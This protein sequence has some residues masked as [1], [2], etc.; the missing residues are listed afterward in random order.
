M[1]RFLGILGRGGNVIAIGFGHFLHLFQGPD[2]FRQFFP[3]PDDV[4]GHDAAAAVVQI[5]AFLVDQ[6]VDAVESHSPVVPHDAAPAVGVGQTGYNVAVTGPAHFSGVGI[7]HGL[8][9]GLVVFGEDLVELGVHFVPVGFRRFFRHFDAAVGHEGPFQRLVGLEAHHL[10]QILHGFIDVAGAV[11]RQAGNHFRFAVQ[12]AAFGPFFLLE[13]L[14][15]SPQFVGGFRRPCQEAFV[16]VIR[17]IVVLDEIPDIHI[18]RPFH[19][20]K[21]SPCNILIDAVHYRSSF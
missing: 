7:E 15:L 10:F 17:G 18:V 2:L 5:F 20:F 1:Y 11:R 19:A 6:E 9:V 8:V 13:F 16:P 21:T 12:H 3:L 4:V 14:D